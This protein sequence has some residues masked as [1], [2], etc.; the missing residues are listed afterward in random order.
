MEVSMH[1]STTPILELAKHL[2]HQF[3]TRADEADK[4]G[5]LPAEDVQVLK[6]SGYLGLSVPKAY[7]GQGLSMKACLE[8][9]L[10]L[11]Q[12]SAST[13]MVAAMPLQIFGHARE[14]DLFPEAVLERLGRASANGSLV[15]NVASEPLLGSPSR[16]GLSATTATPTPAGDGWVINGHKTWSTGGKHLTHML[17]SVRLEDDPAMML[18]LQ[19]TP[20]LEWI[21]TWSDSLS[22][23]AS[24]S[25][26]V[27]FKN[28]VVPADHLLQRGPGQTPVP[29][30]AWFPMMISITYLGA[31]IAARNGIIHY[32]LERVPTALGK[33]I[34]T[35]PKIQRQIG[36][37]D[38]ALQAARALIFEAAGEWTGEVE[39]RRR[40][41]P[42][43]VAAKY[44]VIEAATEVTEKA[45][46][47]AGGMSITKAL[48]LERHFRDVRA[49]SM[50]PPSG[51]TALEIVGR[52][53]IE[54]VKS[55]RI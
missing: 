24:D 37:I 15:N 30:N 48:P 28:V 6:D 21:E 50:Q 18:V 13:A 29:P 55:G 42:R 36:E 12:G 52:H 32:A 54:Q 39:N 34:A 11:A 19:D 5:K 44:Q 41:Y 26:D 23:R 40:V 2:A 17:V 3:A 31:A 8:A 33:P 35:L 38:V 14:V 7:G 53:A 51:D 27:Y 45:L 1:I 9:H 46:R 49:G 16:G 25:H 43:L 20:G 4:L 10:E 47:I 22:L